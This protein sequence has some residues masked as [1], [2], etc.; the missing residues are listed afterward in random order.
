[1][2]YAHAFQD[3]HGIGTHWLPC[4]GKGLCHVVL[5]TD[6][7]GRH[8]PLMSTCA[9]AADH[10]YHSGC[11]PAPE[12]LTVSPPVCF[13]PGAPEAPECPQEPRPP[14]V[15]WRLNAGLKTLL[16]GTLATATTIL[17]LATA[18]PVTFNLLASVL[19]A[20]YVWLLAGLLVVS[21]WLHNA[22][23]HRADP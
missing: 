20:R 23:K 13:A 11:L 9:Q 3:C 15:G 14:L 12:R 6:V 5:A 4:P 19:P 7:P 1:M 22:A 2:E 10:E 8:A 16:R 18:D 21:G 17:T